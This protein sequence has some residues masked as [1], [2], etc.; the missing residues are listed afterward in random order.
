MAWKYLKN[1]YRCK[2]WLTFML[3]VFSCSAK[4]G[5]NLSEKLLSIEE[6]I[7]LDTLRSKGLSKAQELRLKDLNKEL[8]SLSKDIQEPLLQR[9]R[10]ANRRQAI[11][12]IF[13]DYGMY[14]EARLYFNAAIDYEGNNATLFYYRALCSAWLMKNSIEGEKRSNYLQQAIWDYQRSLE[15]KSDYTDSLYGLAV[16]KLFEQQDYTE[17]AQLLDR[18]I[19]KRNISKKASPRPRAKTLREA[20]RIAN[21]YGQSPKNKDISALFI[22]A[23]A[24]YGLGQLNEAASFYDWAASAAISSEVRKR[25]EQLKSQVLQGNNYRVETQ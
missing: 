11:A 17:T 23:Q 21:N 15:I 13:M 18:Y 14:H 12:L 3:L 7:P 5:I 25:A 1:I 16:L 24:A 8:L 9:S 6:Q 22:R 20:Q 2:R 19:A 4:N 10:Y